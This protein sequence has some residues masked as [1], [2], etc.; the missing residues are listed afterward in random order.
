MESWWK[1]IRGGSTWIDLSRGMKGGK[2]CVS[3]VDAHPKVASAQEFSTHLDGMAHPVDS[4]SPPPPQPSLSLSKGPINKVTL[5]A[6]KEAMP[7]LG[8]WTTTQQD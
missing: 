2:I 6:E 3:H 7:G 4:Q 1:D 5:V 8:T